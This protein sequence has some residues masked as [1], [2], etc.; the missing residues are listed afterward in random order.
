V[1]GLDKLAEPA[2]LKALRVQI[3]EMLPRV[4]LPEV[5]LEPTFRTSTFTTI[6]PWLKLI[7]N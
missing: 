3:A 1:T 2:S 4:D 6:S 7:E 5:L